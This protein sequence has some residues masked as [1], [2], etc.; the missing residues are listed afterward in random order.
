M[1]VT[2]KIRPNAEVRLQGYP[3][4]EGVALAHV[5]LLEAADPKAVTYYRIPKGRAEEELA[6]VH[7]AV[8]TASAQLA[9]IVSRVSER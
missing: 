1:S 4:S 3:L 5:V 9:L 2:A 8:R 6:R 7:E